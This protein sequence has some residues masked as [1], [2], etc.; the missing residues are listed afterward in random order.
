MK[1]SIVIPVYNEGAIL[2]ENLSLLIDNFPDTEII[3]IDDGS[4]DNTEQLAKKFL[5]NIRYLK[6]SKNTGKG[7]AIKRGMLEAKGDYIVFT[8][9][10]LPFGVEGIKKIIDELISKK[11]QIVIAEKLNYEKVFVYLLVRKIVGNL[12]ALMFGFTLD[13]TQA[14]LKGFSAE[15]REKIFPNTFINRFACDIEMLC[16]AKKQGFD[17]VSVP[18]EVVPD[19]K[20]LSHFKFTQ[21]I[22]F[23]VDVFRIRFHRYK[24]DNMPLCKNSEEV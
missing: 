8:D 6:S 13:D 23:M 2:Q 20:R 16:L 5:K 17:V 11:R 22:I 1:L 12:V 9:A 14:G 4:S 19:P 10:D 3:L 15:S 21:G 24:N 7:Y 18:V